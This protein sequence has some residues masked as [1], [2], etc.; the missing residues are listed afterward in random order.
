[1]PRINTRGTDQKI[2]TAKGREADA[3]HVSNTAVA[4]SAIAGASAGALIGSI[5]PGAGTVIGAL[6]GA[7]IA[8]LTKAHSKQL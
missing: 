1:M 4:N 6:A 8:G 5:I 2:D 3:V 7:A